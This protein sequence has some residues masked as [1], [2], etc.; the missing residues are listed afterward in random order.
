MITIKQL[1]KLILICAIMTG[2][3][4]V[5]LSSVSSHFNYIV[6]SIQGSPLKLQLIPAIL[7]Y[8]V[9]VGGL[10]YFI[11]REN[12][13]IWDAAILGWVIYAVFE[14]TNKA[15]FKNWDWFSVALDTFWGGILFSLTTF[16]IYKL[17]N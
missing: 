8:I 3:D 14:T 13:S 16:F 11:I 5:Y 9:L 12:K 10:Y 6:Q 2:I 4:F 15:I 1:Q 7:C 17:Y